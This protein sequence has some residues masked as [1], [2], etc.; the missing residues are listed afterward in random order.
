[1]KRG[2]TKVLLEN[3]RTGLGFTS[4]NAIA[5]PPT[6][7]FAPPTIYL[8]NSGLEEFQHPEFKRYGPK[9]SKSVYVDTLNETKKAPNAPI[10]KDWVSD[11]DEDESEVMMVQKP[12]LKNVEKGTCQRDVRPAW[13]NTIRINHQNFSN[14]KR[15][16][17]PTAVLT[18][19][20]IVPISTAR[21][22]S[23]RATA[24]ISVARPINTA[25]PKPLG[26]KVTSAVGK[27]GN[28]AVK[29][30]ACWVW[31]PKIKVQD[32]VSKNSRSYICK[33]F[34]YVDPEGRLK[35]EYDEGYV[36]FGGG[37]KGGK[38]SGKGTIRTGKLDFEDVYFVKE[39]QF[40]LF[41]VSQMCDKKNSI[42]F[43]D[44]ECLVLSTNFK[45]TDESQVLFKV[46]NKN[47]MYSFDMK[48]IVPQK[49]L[50][51]LLAKAKNDASMLWHRRLSHINFK[52][53]NKLVKD[54]L[55]RGLPSKYFENDQT[56]VACLKGKQHKV[57]FKSKIQ[58]F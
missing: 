33:R 8:S 46:P 39:L 10:I 49:D 54:N 58:N 53:I 52:N 23:S 24:L 22:S 43:T 44:T 7:L 45:L 40:N 25:A 56:C 12:V 17:A 35:S 48:N 3:C 20:R 14:S 26:N 2:V 15:N 11:S 21:Q 57:S 31:R 38:I 30:S 1:M 27:Q 47:N 19:S 51:F 18:K 32:H 29:F 37:A 55:V 42:R 4:Y 16:F 41:S 13:D 28:N 6:R 5:P 9:D 36:A 50:T 34:D